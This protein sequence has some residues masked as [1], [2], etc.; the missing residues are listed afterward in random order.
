[1]GK[2]PAASTLCAASAAL[3]H[4]R[5]AAPPELPE[6]RW[7][8]A[9]AEPWGLRMACRGITCWSMLTINENHA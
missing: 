2:F 6:V 9:L 8:S 4:P 7:H 1:M 3:R 5:L